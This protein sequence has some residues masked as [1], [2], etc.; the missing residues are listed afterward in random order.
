LREKDLRREI[1][2]NKVCSAGGE[3]Q[4]MSSGE[5]AGAR[6]KRK[7]LVRHQLI[8]CGKRVENF[9]TSWRPG[10]GRRDLQKNPGLHFLFRRKKDEEAMIGES[11]GPRRR[12]AIR[13][14][15]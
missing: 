6:G 3:V 15:N 13:D 11:T 12:G 5:N 9:A 4:E 14:E 7:F 10:K 2:Y 8:M 1:V